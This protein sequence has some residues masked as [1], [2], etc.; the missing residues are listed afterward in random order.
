MNHRTSTQTDISLLSPWLIDSR[1][2]WAHYK[3]ATFNFQN[4]ASSSIRRMVGVNLSSLL[5]IQTTPQQVWGGLVRSELTLIFPC[6][7][8][9]CS[10]W[11]Q[12]PVQLLSSPQIPPCSEPCPC[13]RAPPAYG[14]TPC[15]EREKRRRVSVKKRGTGPA[16]R[17]GDHHMSSVLNSAMV[18]CK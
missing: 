18:R 12:Q 16:V 3:T 15:S 5:V 6:C 1:I 17:P 4:G 11:A 13:G 10:S 9:R 8:K 14:P 2:D 7:R